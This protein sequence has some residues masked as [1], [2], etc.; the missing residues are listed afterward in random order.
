[1]GLEAGRKVQ[2]WEPS[3]EVSGLAN[4]LA[5]F[6]GVLFLV[7]SQWLVPD[8]DREGGGGGLTSLLTP[9]PQLLSCQIKI[10]FS[11]L[12]ILY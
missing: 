3:G 7:L 5:S 8:N 9:S 11:K 1:M 2:S 4:H 12:F 10:M 6:L